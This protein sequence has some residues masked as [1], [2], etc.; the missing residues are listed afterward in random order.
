METD[1][2]A[3]RLADRMERDGI[4]LVEWRGG[5][6]DEI[7]AALINAVLSIRARYGTVTNGV[8]GAVGRYRDHEQRR[9]DDL[10]VLAKRKPE[11][12]ARQ[13]DNHA[14]ASGRLKADL[15]VDAA[16]RLVDAG[17]TRAGDL[18]P[19]GD[20]HRRAYTGVRGL[21]AVTWVYFAMML[22]HDGVKADTWIQ[23]Y[24]AHAVGAPLEPARAEA[25]VAAVA[26]Q[27]Q[28]EVRQVDQA[29]WRF[30][31]SREGAA[32]LSDS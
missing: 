18:D 16:R 7:E 6:P 31:R 3:R 5:Y 11:L 10:T 32:S 17:V 19:V 28:V 30:A 29:I 20:R 15:I 23:K 26:A 27:Q 4:Q 25:V 8:R 13:L 14:R 12:L 22:G 24:V 9:L 1:A 2:A 21:G